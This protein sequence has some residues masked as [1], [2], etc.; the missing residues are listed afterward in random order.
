MLFRSLSR[1]KTGLENDQERIVKNKTLDAENA[2]ANLR[3]K[4]DDYL[5]NK[6]KIIA[7]RY[8]TALEGLTYTKEVVDG[9]YALVAGAIGESAVVKTLQQ[10]SDDCYLIN[11][12]SVSFDPPIFNKR[13]NDRIFSIQIDHVLVCESGVFLL[14]TKN[15]S[16]NSV[17]NL[18]L[19]SPIKQVLRTN[20]ALFVLLNGDSAF[21]DM[22]LEPHHWGVKKIPIRNV[23]VMINDR[24]REEFKHVKVLSINELIGYVKYFDH[25]LSREEVKNIFEY[26]KARMQSKF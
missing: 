18:D 13:E 14:E 12:F 16:K 22:R 26:L 8:K 21:N 24:P 2:V 1:R 7:E 6:N 15:W 20:F 23:I 17:G 11:D 5:E 25:V 4:I 19:R 3:K 10:L 9:L